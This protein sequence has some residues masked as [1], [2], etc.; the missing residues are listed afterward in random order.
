MGL[1]SPPD[2]LRSVVG[3]VADRDIIYAVTIA[4]E[5]AALD[6]ATGRFRVV[7]SSVAMGT[8]S[9]NFV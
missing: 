9:Y 8:V 6:L 7:D 5:L 1:G 3:F 2:D 4:D